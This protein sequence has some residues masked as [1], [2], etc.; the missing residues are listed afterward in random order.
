MAMVFCGGI[1]IFS[2]LARLLICLDVGAS[3]PTYIKRVV[4]SRTSLSPSF[5][6]VFYTSNC[7]N[8]PSEKM[9]KL[10]FLLFIITAYWRIN[11]TPNCK[12]NDVA[13]NGAALN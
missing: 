11:I 1:L 7:I 13:Q 4:D 5:Y 2:T 12:I 9:H 10:L 8:N 3:V 6:V